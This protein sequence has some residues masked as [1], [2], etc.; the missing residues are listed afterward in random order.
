LAPTAVPRGG[1]IEVEIAGTLAAPGFVVRCRG[2]SARPPQYLGDFVNGPPPPI[3]AMTIQAY[4][5]VRLAMASRMHL[6]IVKDG[7]DVMLTAKG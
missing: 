3:N 1:E 5:T 6:A 7:A 2:T 4:Y